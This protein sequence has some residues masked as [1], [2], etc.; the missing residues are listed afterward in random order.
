MTSAP[1]S[2]SSGVNGDNFIYC[3]IGKQVERVPI[4]S[5]LQERQA[6]LFPDV[7]PAIPTWTGYA[8]LFIQQTRNTPIDNPCPHKNVVRFTKQTRCSDELETTTIVCK[9]CGYRTSK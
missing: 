5:S 4:V 6:V 1:S 9:D 2:S 3:R 8:R 7:V